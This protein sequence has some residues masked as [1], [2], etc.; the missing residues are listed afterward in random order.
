MKVVSRQWS[1]VSLIL[2]ALLFALSFPAEAQ[3]PTK[4]PQVGFLAFGSPSSYA[5]RV[6]A[7]RGGL[8]QLGYI[9]GKN[10]QIDYQYAEKGFDLLVAN[11]VRR[12]VDVIVTGG[13]PPS[14]AA[15]K[16]TTT[17]PIVVA[18]SGDTVGAGLVASLA[19]PGGNV[20][21]LTSVASD[22][23]ANVDY[24]ALFRRAAVYVDKI[25]KG[26]TPADLPVEQPTKF[27]FAIN[28][29]T[30]KQ[31]GLTIP[32]DVLSRADKVIR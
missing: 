3:K 8:R 2:C 28:L 10:I 23:R 15:K 6:E 32:P 30:A 27:E 1:V 26:A 18:L 20:T 19:H 9:D 22:L 16:A 17:I 24:P 21:G 14:K 4:V 7:F 29:K 25:L 5:A 12:K 31:I 11:M 13:T